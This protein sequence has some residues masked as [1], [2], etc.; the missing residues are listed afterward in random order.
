M[1]II[2]IGALEQFSSSRHHL[3]FYHNVGISATYSSSPKDLSALK[4]IIFS[5][6]AVVVSRHSVLSAIPIDEDTN[7]P[8]F[9]CLRT[10]NLEEAVTFMTRQQPRSN[11]AFDAELDAILSEQHHTSFKARYGELPFWRLII[12]TNPAVMRTEFS[13]SFVFHHALGDGT[14]GLIFHKDFHSALFSSKPLT[15]YTIKTPNNPLPPKLEAIH[16]LPI[17]A[18]TPAPELPSLYQ[19]TPIFLP[20]ISRFRSFT[21]STAIATAF[22]AVC[23]KN[24]TTL[25]AT[26]P[27]ILS[28]VLSTLIPAQYETFEATIPVSLRRLLPE[29]HTNT[30]EMGIYIDA[31]STYCTRAPF[32]W[33]AARKSK[34]AV[35][36]YLRQAD[37]GHF[38]IA[39][40][41][42]VED[43][44]EY[45]SSR[46]GSERGSSFG[47]SNLGVLKLDGETTHGKGEEEWKMGRVVFSRSAFVAGSAFSTGL[48]TGP[49]G[50]LCVGFEWQ[51]GVVEE[52][53]MDGLVEGVREEIARIVRE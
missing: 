22:L 23:R 48:V 29:P 45:F 14:A 43:F 18:A 53:L 7:D 5:A 31:F 6:L 15:S 16:P 40:L 8:Y 32:S 25:T 42:N 37:L 44:N 19:G 3:G 36:A 4:E 30:Q 9:A 26:I 13:A 50:C 47:V 27:I 11:D 28:S 1:L 34:A 39:K 41:K 33:D 35:D 38:K 12:L 17:T 21:L 2:E 24:K 46:L 20:L 49:D 52:N 51:E 10:I